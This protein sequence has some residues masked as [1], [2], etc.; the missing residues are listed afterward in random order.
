MAENLLGISKWTENDLD[1]FYDKVNLCHKCIR[2]GKN[3]KMEL[4]EGKLAWGMQMD[5]KFMFMKKL[6]PGGCLPLPWGYIHVY[7]HNIQTSTSLKPLY[8]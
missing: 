8:Q 2:R 1:I 5:R 4:N 6:T 7:D 3:S